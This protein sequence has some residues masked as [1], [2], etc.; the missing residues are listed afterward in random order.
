MEFLFEAEILAEAER[1][2]AQGEGGAPSRADISGVRTVRYGRGQ[3][4]PGGRR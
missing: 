1:A 3:P 4:G 2:P